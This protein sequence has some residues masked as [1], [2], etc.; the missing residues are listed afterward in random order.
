MITLFAEAYFDAKE[1]TLK[2]KAS[3]S[4]FFSKAILSGLLSLS[5]ISSPKDSAIIVIIIYLFTL[6]QKKM[7]DKE[8]QIRMY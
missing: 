5:F 3:G 4:C 8:L 2:F 6:E 7:E 1:W